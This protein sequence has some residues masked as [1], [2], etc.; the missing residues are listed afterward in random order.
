MFHSCK[1]RKTGDNLLKLF[2]LVETRLFRVENYLKED[3]AK[4]GENSVKNLIQPVA[5]KKE[6]SWN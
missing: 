6:E 4:K 5:T 3:L 2:C 1:I